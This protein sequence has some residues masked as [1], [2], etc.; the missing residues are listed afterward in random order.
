M[1]ITDCQWQVDVGLP[2]AGPVVQPDRGRKEGPA[3]PLYGASWVAKPA[4]DGAFQVCYRL[5]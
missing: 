3:M 4:A 5:M 2:G 1:D